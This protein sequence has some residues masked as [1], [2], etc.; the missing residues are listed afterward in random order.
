MADI[1]GALLG[2]IGAGVQG[3]T[4]LAQLIAGL[5][6]QNDRPQR[7]IPPEIEQNLNQAQ[8]QYLQGLPDEQYNQAIQNFQRNIA[9]GARTL[10]DRNS[11]IGGVSNLVQQANDAT[12][13]LDVADANAR[14]QKLGAL[15]GARQEVA[16]QKIENWNWNERDKYL[17]KA[18]AKQ[19][20]EGAGIQNINGGVNTALGGFAQDNF[21][22]LLMGMNGGGDN[23][24]WLNA[25]KQG[26]G[27]GFGNG[28]GSGTW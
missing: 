2:G 6:M 20:L 21:S 11:A 17:Q 7:V 13:G 28:G 5:S 26:G 16:N 18:Q 10:Q 19:A 25:L 22:K 1:T 9:F 4:G 3:V 12:L 8:F 27:A 23:Y 15:Y 24:S 14:N